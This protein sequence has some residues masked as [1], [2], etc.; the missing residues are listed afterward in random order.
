MHWL[1]AQKRTIVLAILIIGVL[2][3]AVF[4]IWRTRTFN[5]DDALAFIGM[6]LPDGSQS[7]QFA[8][9][10]Q[11]TRIVWLRFDVAPTDDTGFLSRVGIE[12]QPRNQ[13]TPFVA[14]NPAE[15]GLQWWMPYNAKQ[16][17]GLWAIA[18][19]KVYEVL[20]DKTQA[21]KTTVYLRVYAIIK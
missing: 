2:I 21:D 20:M 13:F 9:S 11:I 16:F 12:V 4:G 8:T 6:K 18:H 10:G 5:L 3:A 14:V 7:V 17:S 1:Q 15:T 19:N